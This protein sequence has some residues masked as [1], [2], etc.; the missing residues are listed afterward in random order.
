[1]ETKV[2]YKFLPMR[3]ASTSINQRVNH[4]GV[5]LQVTAKFKFVDAAD[6][7]GSYRRIHAFV[8]A[9]DG[10]TLFNGHPGIDSLT[11]K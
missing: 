11:R 6:P 2:G 8:Y 3:D 1:M 10:E 5:I 7:R 9:E 4:V